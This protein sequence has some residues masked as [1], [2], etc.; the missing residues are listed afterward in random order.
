MQRRAAS[1]VA[2]ARR[3]TGRRTLRTVVTIAMA[4]IAM[5]TSPRLIGLGC[6]LQVKSI[7]TWRT[8]GPEFSCLSSSFWARAAQI[9]ASPMVPGC[10]SG[11]SR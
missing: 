6:P 5:K 10:S 3:G 2:T 8:I 11:S 1:C 7:G 9:G 4:E